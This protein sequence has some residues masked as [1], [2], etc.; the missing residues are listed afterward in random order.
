MRLSLGRLAPALLA[1]LLALGACTQPD[2]AG[3]AAAPA[4]EDPA[5]AGPTEEEETPTLAQ[6]WLGAL[7]TRQKVGQLFLIRSPGDGVAQAVAQYQ[8]GGV[9]FFAA[10]FAGKSAEQVRQMTAACQAAAVCP[11]LTAVDEEGGTVNRVSRYPALRAQ[12]FPSPQQLLEEGGLDAVR[13]DA[14]EKSAFLLDLGLNV[15]LAPVCDVSTDP[16]DF[17]YP[18]ACGLDAAGTSRYTAAVVEEMGRAGIGSVLKHFP[19]YGGNGDTHTGIVTDP[20]GLEEFQKRDFLPFSAGI[21]AGAGAVLVSHTIVPALDGAAP[22]SLSPAVHRLLR[23]E[24]GFDGVMITDD[25]IMQAI[26][27]RYGEEQAAILAVQAGNDL[28]ISSDYVTQLAAVQ[29]AVERGAITLEEL[30]AAVLRVLT[31]KER[32]GLLPALPE[33]GVQP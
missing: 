7:T 9:V 24:L 18:R 20:R 16:A 10:D 31:W 3:P 26:T 2:T 29:A 21:D 28:L 23:Q 27:D 25:L 12:P 32:L 4:E 22:A 15:N 13:Q 6:Q 19:G 17:I 1:L 11:L 5:P 30:D 33:G 14:R 8:P